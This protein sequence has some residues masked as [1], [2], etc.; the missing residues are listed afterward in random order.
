MWRWIL[1]FLFGE[2]KS[3]A[4][5]PTHVAEEELVVT[6]KDL[7][8]EDLKACFLEAAKQA[9]EERAKVEA[10]L[11]ASGK[12]RQYIKNTL[13]Y[14]AKECIKQDAYDFILISHHNVDVP[15]QVWGTYMEVFMKIAKEFGIE[16]SL[17]GEY[18]KVIKKSVLKTFDG[19]IPPPPAPDMT[20]LRE[21]LRTGPYR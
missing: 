15:N 20:A 11:L 9:A 12:M 21:L 1:T 2:R 19:M 6:E 14:M 5:P 8:T 17:T 7:V 13:K 4:L 16:A 18:I 10:E 3:K